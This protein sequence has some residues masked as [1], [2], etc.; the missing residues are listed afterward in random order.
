MG[1]EVYEC[2][3]FVCSSVRLQG[4]S[5]VEGVVPFDCAI[6][7][8]VDFLIKN[9]LPRHPCS[10]VPDSYTYHLDAH[11]HNN[12]ILIDVKNHSNFKEKS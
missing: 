5:V 12:E 11:W 10:P 8:L 6:P 3:N 1:S 9:T 4:F 7:V 2:R